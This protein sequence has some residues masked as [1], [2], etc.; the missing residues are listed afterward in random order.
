MKLAT[1]RYN[2]KTSCGIVTSRGLVD[3][4]SAW[5]GSDAPHSVMEILQRGPSCLRVLASLPHESGE[6]LPLGSVTLLA[7]LP[8][9]GKLLA[10]AGNYAE[11]VKEASLSRGFQ[12]G[13]SDSPRLTTVP[14]PFL[15]PASVI[16][17]PGDTIPWPAYSKQIDYELE[18]AVVIGS[19]VKGV[20]ADKAL[21]SVAG[22]MI[23]NDVSAR[24]VTFK[25][26]RSE[27][28]WDE[29]YD[30]LNGKWADGFLP[31]GPY[32]VTKDEI[33]DVQ[34]LHM[35]LKVNGQ[36]RQNANTSQ[37]IYPVADVV[38]FLSHLMTLEPGD[39]I[40]TGTPSGVAIATGNFLQGGDVIECSIE[41]L[42]TLT[43]TL[44]PRPEAFY[45]PLK[46]S[47]SM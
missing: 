17:G 32:L 12:L 15:M 30:W 33:A 7:P 11:H 16:S 1:Y 18:L 29:F 44:G 19:R 4:P 35:V 14:R 23:A 10:L 47:A 39:I 27:R 26:G 24:S 40:S 37:M 21:D 3:I 45:E 6:C 22:Y 2:H 5:P 8:Q 31:T 34:N 36:V 41:G 28:P 46:R 25:E 43:N 20:N 42:G 38:S 9:P 13:L